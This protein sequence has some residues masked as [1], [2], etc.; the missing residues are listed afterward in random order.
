[1]IP[2]LATRKIALDRRERRHDRGYNHSKAVKPYESRLDR[3]S[4][5]T[6]RS[7]ADRREFG[8]AIAEAAADPNLQSG[9]NGIRGGTD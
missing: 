1:M 7:I 3:V 8:Q 6:S 5:R 4:P 2:Q 9:A